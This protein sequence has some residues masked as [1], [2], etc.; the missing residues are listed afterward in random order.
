M[1]GTSAQDELRSCVLR[2]GADV[3]DHA[4]HHFVETPESRGREREVVSRLLLC[5]FIPDFRQCS[6][7]ESYGIASTTLKRCDA[8]AR[9]LRMVSWAARGVESV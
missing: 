5:V 8:W 3:L 4:W 1:E 2:I 9:V 7:E 6:L